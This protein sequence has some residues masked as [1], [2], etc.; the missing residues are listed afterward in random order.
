MLERECTRL[1]IGLAAAG[2]R[3]EVARELATHLGVEDVLLLA[4]DS[5][6]GVMLPA[7]GMPQTLAGGPSWAAMLQQCLEPGR[8]RCVV[9]LPRGTQRDAVALCADGAAVVLLGAEP[10]Q[11]ALEAIALQL[12]LLAALLCAERRVMSS[13]AQ[14]QLERGTA[15]HARTLAQALETARANASRLVGKLREE[16]HRKDEFLAT[17]AHELRNP[18]APITTAVDVLRQPGIPEAMRERL[19]ET[20]ARQVRQLARLVDDLLDVSRVS[21]GRVALR[22][23]SIDLRE[24]LQS[25]LEAS[26]PIIESRNHAV[27]LELPD[28]AVVVH[29]DAV[30]VV[31]VF[32]N[33]LHNAA[34]YTDPGGRIEV[35]LAARAGSAEVVVRDT[36]IG[37]AP[38]LL[39]RVFE[40]FHQA[41]ATI[42]RSQGGLGIGLTLVR[43]LVDMHGGTV[44]ASSE[45]RGQGSSFT[46][47][48]P[49]YSGAPVADTARRPDGGSCGRSLRVLVVDDNR[50]AACAFADMLRLHGHSVEAVFG[51]ESALRA[52]EDSEPDL[53]VLDIG[54]P[55]IDGYEVARRLRRRLPAHTSIVALTGY[56]SSGDRQRSHE[57]GFDAHFVKPA[58]ADT[59]EQ[60]LRLCRR[61]PAEDPSSN[62]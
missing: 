49:L 53:I 28:A 7:P 32:S 44:R 14:A 61:Q 52:A 12:P 59:V 45:G 55:D 62:A 39:D 56:G 37:I 50:D 8:H 11:A 6:A 35:S 24:A 48:L 34:K 36:G 23:E 21:R 3:A 20:M 26:L 29:G 25:A 42:D 13:D 58:D 31:Q 43:R 18:L 60:M 2:R 27:T 51:A 1:L 46:V 38:E 5:E 9:D 33:L 10:E 47:R 4:R 19:V 16:H 22:R 41:P 15:L 30:R 17:L 57:A 40:L 54:L